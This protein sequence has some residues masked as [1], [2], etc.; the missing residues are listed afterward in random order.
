MKIPELDLPTVVLAPGDDALLAR[1][2]EGGLYARHLLDE[3]ATDPRLHDVVR[4]GEAAA[5]KLAWVGIRMAIKYARRTAYVS[6]LPEEEL[7]QDGCVAVAE[8]IRR[9][10]HTRTFR[11]TTFVHEYLVREMTDGGRHRIGHP[12]VSRADRRAARQALRTLDTLGLEDSELAVDAVVRATGLS[13]GA[14][15]RGR[16]RLVSLDLSLI[17]EELSYEHAVETDLDFLALLLPRH[18]RVLRLRY[19][20][21]GRPRTL[22]ETA[23]IMRASPSTVSRWERE[24]LEAARH[25]LT[26]EE[27]TRAAAYRGQAAAVG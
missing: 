24:A 20:L 2:I 1:A 27:T 16:I 26:G 3:G 14:T 4:R 17:A 8:A 13:P 22:V 18:R 5:E 12:S 10:D 25:L 6:G 9:Y 7:F 21:A 15:Q 19:G 23:Q 11:F